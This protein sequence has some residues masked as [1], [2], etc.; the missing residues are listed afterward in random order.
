MVKESE[1]TGGSF[2]LCS[3]GTS[4]VVALLWS[5]VSAEGRGE[6]SKYIAD[7]GDGGGASDTV[8]S[9]INGS[10]ANITIVNHR[11]IGSS[12]AKSVPNTLNKFSMGRQ[13]RQKGRVFQCVRVDIP[14][15]LH[16]QL[17]LGSSRRTQVKEM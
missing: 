17:Q 4:S 10:M 1:Q 6:G 14:P 9:H 11:T 5:A 3:N 7:I 8:W 13:D 15:E 12:I 2:F 16:R